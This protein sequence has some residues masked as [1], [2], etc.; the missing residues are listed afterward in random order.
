MNNSMQECELFRSM[1]AGS[2]LFY[3]IDFLDQLVAMS[4]QNKNLANL[5]EFKE[6]LS[7]IIELRNMTAEMY[8]AHID[9][10]IEFLKSKKA[11]ISPQ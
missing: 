3:C 5:P 11:S 4:Q 2:R 10:A 9:A 6:S 8:N 1:E 7:S